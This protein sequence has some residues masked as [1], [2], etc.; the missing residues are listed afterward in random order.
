M[1]FMIMR[2]Q[3]QQAKK[4]QELLS[5]LSAGQEVVTVGGI[6]GTIVAI[7]DTTA[8]LRVAPNVEMTFNRSAIGSAKK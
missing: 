8:R 1:Y 2:P 7:D 5:S 4:R 6:H 3:Q